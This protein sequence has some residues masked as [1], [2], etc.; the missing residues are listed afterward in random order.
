M[1]KINLIFL[2]NSHEI[3]MGYLSFSYNLIWGNDEIAWIIT[4]S[5][6]GLELLTIM[7]Y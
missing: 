4:R 6:L 5:T 7:L 1:R 3:P 2:E